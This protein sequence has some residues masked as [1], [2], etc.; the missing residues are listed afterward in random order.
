MR[1]AYKVLVRKS[2]RMRPIGKPRQ[3]EDYIKM[4]HK[5]RRYEGVDWIYQD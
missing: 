3:V 2:E 1:N 4:D 5:K